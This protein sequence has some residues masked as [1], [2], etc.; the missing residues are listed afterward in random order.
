MIQKQI[1]PSLIGGKTY[2]ADEEGNIINQKGHRLKVQLS[3]RNATRLKNHGEEYPHLKFDKERR[4][5]PLVCAAFWGLAPADHVCHHLDGNKLNNRPDNLIW[6][7]RDA[8]P[9]FD[10]V[11]RAGVILR[12]VAPEQQIEAEINSTND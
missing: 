6:V 2:F 12:H 1:P 8:H 3:K 9:A 10:R 11:M 4:I 7:R 5:A